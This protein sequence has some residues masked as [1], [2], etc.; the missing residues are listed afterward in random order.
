LKDNLAVFLQRTGKME[1]IF[2]G[3]YLSLSEN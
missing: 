3:Y 2:S 1:Y